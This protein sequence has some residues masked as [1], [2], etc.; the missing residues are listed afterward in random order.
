MPLKPK[1][2]YIF[3]SYRLDADE[4]VLLRDGQ[5]VALPPKDLETLIVLVEKAGHIV[6]KEELLEKVWPGVFIEENNLARRV[7]NLRQVLGEGPD[8]RKYIETV[9]KRGYRFVGSVR[10]LGD[11]AESTAPAPRTSDSP[12]STLQTSRRRTRWPW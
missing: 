6:G 4:R 9:P 5:P 11:S 3:G 12:H 8:G 7:F 10:G 2:L 1:H